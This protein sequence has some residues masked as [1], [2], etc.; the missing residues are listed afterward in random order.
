MRIRVTRRG[1]LAGI[2]LRGEIDT[3]ELPPEQG[4]LAEAALHAL[5]D[6]PAGAP[7]SHPDGFQY[8]IAFAPANGAARSMLIDEAAV[9]DGLQPLIQTAMGRGTLGK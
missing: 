6:N 3:A 2:P 7:P 8:E 4:M 9:P 1:G 5:P